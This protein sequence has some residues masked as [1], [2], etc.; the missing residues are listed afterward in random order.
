MN[1][2]WL[3]VV[4]DLGFCEYIIENMLN[5][6]M[7]FWTK[8]ITVYSLNCLPLNFEGGKIRDIL[9]TVFWGFCDIYFEL[10]T[11]MKCAWWLDLIIRWLHFSSG[12]I[13]FWA[14]HAFPSPSSS[15]ENKTILGWKSQ[16]YKF[17]ILI[18]FIFKITLVRYE[19][20]VPSKRSSGPGVSIFFSPVNSKG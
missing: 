5:T 19:S 13:F 11:F 14:I 15:L 4:C 8:T 7:I 10:K 20:P 2:V 1:S 3:F 18:F 12:W 16:K 9:Q 17:F 6:L